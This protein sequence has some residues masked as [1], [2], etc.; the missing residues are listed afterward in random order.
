MFESR[1]LFLAALVAAGCDSSRPA[2]TRPSRGPDIVPPGTDPGK[3]DTMAITAPRP[4][5]PKPD[6]TRMKFDAATRTLELYDL[7]GKGGRWMLRMPGDSLP[8]PVDR[9]HRFAPDMPLDLDGVTVFYVVANGKAST[10][11]TL[12]DILTAGELRAGR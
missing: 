4:Q 3:P 5:L 7:P 1:M 2:D 10:T 9:V 8:V 6:L 12:R 11:V